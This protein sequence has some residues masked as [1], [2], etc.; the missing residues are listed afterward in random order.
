M[1]KFIITR[2]ALKKLLK[3][4]LY[5][6]TKRKMITAI[7]KTHELIKPTGRVFLH[8]KEKHK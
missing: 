8:T 2:S 3:R 4:F 6:E 5:P 7:M 1:R